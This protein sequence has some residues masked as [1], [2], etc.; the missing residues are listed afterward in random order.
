[1]AVVFPLLEDEHAF[2][3]RALVPAEAEAPV[4]EETALA[5]VLLREAAALALVLLREAAALAPVPRAIVALAFVLLRE[6]VDLAAVPRDVADVLRDVAALV[7]VLLRE[8]AALAAVPRTI[9]ALAFVLLR[10]AAALAVL[11]AEAVFE[12]AEADAALDFFED[13]PAADLLPERFALRTE[14]WLAILLSFA[15]ELP[16]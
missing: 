16:Q 5:L 15:A 7:P 2:V 11:L 6:A 8:A 3:E 13:V 1:M 12:F 4:P 9:V 14:F 10:E